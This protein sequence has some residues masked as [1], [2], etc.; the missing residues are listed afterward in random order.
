L[1]GI[2]GTSYLLIKSYLE[3]RHQRIKLE[4]S[5]HKS[6]CSWGIIW[7]GVPQGSI[8]G[9]LLFLLYINDITKITNTK[10]NNNKSQV[11][12][13]VD[14]TSLHTISSNPTNFV[15]D[16]NVTFTDI[17]N[18]FKVNLLTLY[19]EK[20]NLIQFLTK[21]RSNIP[22]TVDCDINAEISQTLHDTFITH[23]NLLLII[24]FCIILWHYI[25]GK[26]LRYSKTLYMTKKCC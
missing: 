7:H 22:F 11:V 9:L 1:Y 2:R 4:N 5:Y 8:L 25:L 16:I 23:N 19:F 12:L 14:N 6:Y 15:G 24:S 3:D 17:D 21:N 10:D 26:L 13:F 18:W 20:T